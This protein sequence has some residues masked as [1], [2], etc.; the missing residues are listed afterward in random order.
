[1]GND[2]LM[3]NYLKSL[4]NQNDTL[5]KISIINAARYKLQKMT[6]IKKNFFSK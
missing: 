2:K 3:I 4:K 5:T 6:L 1:M